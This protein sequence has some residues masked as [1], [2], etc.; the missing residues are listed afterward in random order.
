MIC[1][2]LAN[3]LGQVPLHRTIGRLC[4]AINGLSVVRKDAYARFLRQC[5]DNLEQQFG[6]RADNVLSLIDH[7]VA[8]C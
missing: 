8:Y 6:S 7:E 1:H 3:L 5:V 4:K 2:E